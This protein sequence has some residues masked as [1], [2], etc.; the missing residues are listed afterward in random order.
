MSPVI[1]RTVNHRLAEVMKTPGG[2]TVEEALARAAAGLEALAGPARE[3]IAGKVGEL[4]A[5]AASPD[6]GAAR[7]ADAYGLAG[8]IVNVAGSLDMPELFAAAYSLC[9]VLDY[10]RTHAFSRQAFAVH[11]GALRLILTQG[12]SPALKGVVDGLK[13]VRDRV[14]AGKVE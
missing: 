13:A 12:Q 2:V 6:G 1:L 9:D 7:A 11:V 14:L 5:I 4:E 10:C 8:D 3:S